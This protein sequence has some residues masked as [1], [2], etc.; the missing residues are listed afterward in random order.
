MAR[1]RLCFSLAIVATDLLALADD[2]FERYSPYPGDGLRHHCL[3]LHAFVDLLLEAES[4]PFPRD[5][6]YLLAMVHDLGLVARFEVGANYMM[7]SAALFA[8]ETQ[9]LELSQATREQCQ[10][11]LTENHRFF[12]RRGQGDPVV[13]AFRRAVWIEHS[14]GFRRYG[15]ASAAIRA[16]FAKFPRDNFDRVLVDFA[17]R[18]LTREPLTLVRGIFF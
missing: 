11:I 1:P 8:R 16:V 2:I 6:A 13:E 17:R 14:R 18:T 4:N 3:R 9:K 15:L 10:K 7:R 12:A 5:L